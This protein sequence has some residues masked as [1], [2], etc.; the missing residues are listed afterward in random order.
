MLL[1][2]L[3]SG[4]LDPTLIFMVILRESP[5]HLFTLEFCDYRWERV[6]QSLSACTDG[7]LTVIWGKGLLSSR[8]RNWFLQSYCV[9]NFKTFRCF[10]WTWIFYPERQCQEGWGQREMFW[11]ASLF[12][13]HYLNLTGLPNSEDV[14]I[15]KVQFPETI[16]CIIMLCFIHV[17]HDVGKNSLGSEGHQTHV[18]QNAVGEC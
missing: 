8:S 6:L 17:K 7:I 3:R 9:D 10:P 14:G 11:E 15:L 4:H 18:W 1:L 13:S 12:L 2:R 5:H 16:K